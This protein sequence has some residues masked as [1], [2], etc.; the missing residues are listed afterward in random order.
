LESD[1][2]RAE[3]VS[4]ESRKYKGPEVSREAE[5]ERECFW[6]SLPYPI[7]AVLSFASIVTWMSGQALLSWCVRPV[8]HPTVSVCSVLWESCYYLIAIPSDGI[9]AQGGAVAWMLVPHGFACA[10]A[11]SPAWQ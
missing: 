2:L 10:M 9:E 3:G 4:K 5:G 8:G 11:W 7:P 1:Y 6:L